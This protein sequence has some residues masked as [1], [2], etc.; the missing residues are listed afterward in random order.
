MVP[1]KLPSARQYVSHICYDYFCYYSR[2]AYIYYGRIKHSSS[3]Y[4]AA[5]KLM[6]DTIVHRIDNYL[7]LC[8]HHQCYHYHEYFIHIHIHIALHQRAATATALD[9]FVRI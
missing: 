7:R 3:V 4:I 9:A 6:P 8:V 2:T 5:R 1:M